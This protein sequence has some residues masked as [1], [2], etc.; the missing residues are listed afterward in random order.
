L[1]SQLEPSGTNWI[2]TKE[3]FASR[4]SS[5]EKIRKWKTGLTLIFYN[6]YSFE[7]N[8]SIPGLE[9]CFGQPVDPA[10]LKLVTKEVA[11]LDM[12][13]KTFEF[14][15]ESQVRRNFFLGF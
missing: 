12:A 5:R 7:I 9:L 6:V 2:K 8:S 13:V 11:E 3:N 10:L 15:S 4:E 14:E 1:V